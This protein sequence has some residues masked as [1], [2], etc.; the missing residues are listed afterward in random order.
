MGNV[1]DQDYSIHNTKHQ[2][3][4]QKHQLI[5]S[6][7]D[8][9]Q[10]V[11]ILYQVTGSEYEAILLYQIYELLI[12]Q[13]DVKFRFFIIDNCFISPEFKSNLI[14]L[15]KRFQFNFQ[16]LNMAWPEQILPRPQQPIKY[17]L[18][19]RIMFL[20]QM[21]PS[22]INRILFKDADQCMNSGTNILEL[23]NFD[24]Q[25]KPIGM[26]LAGNEEKQKKAIQN[27]QQFH[28]QYPEIAISQYFLTATYLIDMRQFNDQ[29]KNQRFR[30]FW[31]DEIEQKRFKGEITDMTLINYAINTEVVELPWQWLWS[32][33]QHGPE[34]LQEAKIMDM[35]SSKREKEN[36]ITKIQLAQQYCPQFNRHLDKLKRIINANQE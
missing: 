7:A 23:W 31:K 10:Y 4:L 34:L 9:Y 11:N 20:D 3:E 15:Y 24:L 27:K 6:I 19:Y 35:H 5:K 22:Q 1:L 32:K 25:N 21:I 33:S 29:M 16:Y 8:S 17:V 28:E 14:I 18:A 30:D 13:R 26:V 36:G 12:T 2:E